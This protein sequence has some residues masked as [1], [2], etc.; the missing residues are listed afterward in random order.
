MI[1]VRY[2]VKSGVIEPYK[3][4][5]FA[6]RYSMTNVAKI[7]MKYDSKFTQFYD[8][9]LTMQIFQQIKIYVKPVGWCSETAHLENTINHALS[10]YHDCASMLLWQCRA[11]SVLKGQGYEKYYGYG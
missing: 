9:E 8:V 2:H 7:G 3:S 6:K 11:E 5:S 4:C 10:Q 1:R